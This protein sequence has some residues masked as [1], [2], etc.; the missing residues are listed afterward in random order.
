[1]IKILPAVASQ[2]LISAVFVSFAYND[3]DRYHYDA[4]HPAMLF[5]GHISSPVYIHVVLQACIFGPAG[6]WRGG[7][8]SQSDL[9][10]SSAWGA[11]IATIIAGVYIA[12]CFAFAWLLRN[13]SSKKELFHLV[14][15]CF[16]LYCCGLMLNLSC[17]VLYGLFTI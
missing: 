1:M 2:L 12:L 6:E 17:A 4:D 14:F 3:L 10:L 13:S 8:L 7:D 5:A 11:V 15:A 16:A 9:I